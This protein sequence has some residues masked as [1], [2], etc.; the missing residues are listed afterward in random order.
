L[1]KIKLVRPDRPEISE[2]MVPTKLLE[3]KSM[4]WTWTGATAEQVIQDQW[5]FFAIFEQVQEEFFN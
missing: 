1:D 2:G 5:H 3:L 4:T